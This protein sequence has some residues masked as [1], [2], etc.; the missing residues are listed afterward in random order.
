VAG[1]SARRLYAV[2]ALARAGACLG[3]AGA[4][5]LGAV[6]SLQSASAEGDTRTL[7]FHHVHTGETVTVTFRRNGRYV[8]AA[9][10]K[11]DWF[12]RDWRRERETHMDPRLFDLLWQ[13]YREV[14]ATQPIDV[15]CGYRAPTTNAMLHARSRG[16]ARF[17]Q[18]ILGKAIDFYIP[19]VPLAKIRAIGLQLQ[20]GGVGFYP[21]SGSPF[22]H[23]DVGTVRHWPSIPRVQLVK[24]FPHGRTVHV[25]ADGRPL[26]GYAQALAEIER[27]G[28]VP[29]ARSL[30][31]ARAAGLITAKE[32]RV[33]ELVG[34]AREEKLVAMVDTGKAHDFGAPGQ[35]PVPEAKAP[36]L[37]ASLNPSV[38][39]AIKRNVPLPTARPKMLA[40]A[41]AAKPSAPVQVAA[42]DL[43]D[44]RGMWSSAIGAGP[45]LPPARTFPFELA[46]D[47]TVTGSTGA[48]AYASEARTMTPARARPMGAHIPALISTAD[49]SATADDSAVVGPVYASAMAIG[50]QSWDS[51]WLRAVMLTPS[52]SGFMTM[53]R[54]GKPDPRWLAELMEKPARSLLM[55]FVR[56]PQ[57]G[58]QTVRFTGSAVVFLAI[59]T[60]TS[61]RTASLQ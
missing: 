50:G 61:A 2:T 35:A 42:N 52:V 4:L 33:A 30:Q 59:E 48:L 25:P 44:R 5:L 38:P 10:E 3:L 24:I 58:M 49:L 21:T 1:G 47:Q 36:T 31:A 39:V 57:N 53:T 7:T 34:E 20:R 18:H 13:V 51:P 46:A 6:N 28:N 12:M 43:F 14:G 37:L 9:L 23:L 16:V 45:A 54:M 32:E 29:N 27:Q 26:P 15:I 60:F 11:L 40:V 41:A 22:V 56:D 55:T 19:G 17:S 8:D